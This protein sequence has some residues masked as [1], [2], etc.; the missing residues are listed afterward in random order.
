MIGSHI[1]PRFYLE[2]FATPAKRKGKPGR[3]WVYEKQKQPDQRATTAQGF[4]N[5][6]FG[7]LRP[8]GSTDGTLEESFE[9]ELVRLE[10]ECDGFLVCD[11]SHLFHWPAGSREKLAFYAALLYSRATQ[12]R[13]HSAKNSRYT[14]GI[15]EKAIEEDKSVL[16][17][18]AASLSPRFNQPVAA[19]EVREML[20]KPVQEQ[21]TPYAEKNDFLTG[22]LANARNIANHILSKPI[23]E[24]LQSPDGVEFITSDNPVISVV[25][26][27]NGKLHPGYGFGKPDVIVLFPLAP[28]ACLAAGAFSSGTRV[29]VG[30]RR[31]DQAMVKE[32]NEALVSICDRYVYS[33]TRSDD[34]R[35]M[36]DS[37]A[38][39][40]RYGVNALMP[41]GL[42]LPSV[43]E[44]RE[45]L[46]QRFGLGE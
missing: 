5:G 43:A 31:I 41:V 46:R 36:V 2:Q 15:F 17:E 34:V 42:K 22:L 45:H 12:R 7:Y 25:Q 16:D 29:S 28:S 33:K 38:G 13:D 9:N 8:D 30:Y 27:P 21:K 18:I 1:I 19:V 32:V 35:R 11:K 23:W 6:Y 37:F 4:E 26:L 44:A 40:F 10:N 20:L 14:A 24:V 39:M 3:I